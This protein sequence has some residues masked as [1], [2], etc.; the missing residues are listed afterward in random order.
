MGARGLLSRLASRDPGRPVDEV[1]SIVNNLRVLLNTRVGDSLSAMGFGVTDFIDLV[2]DAP[3]AAGAMQ[4]SIRAAIT[5]FEPRLRNVRVRNI[6]S[7]DPLA[8]A[9]EVSA[10]LAGD[11]KRGLVRV[12]T[13]VSHAGRIK[14]E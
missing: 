12:R 5:E 7:E 1:T 3:H 8:L 9:F 2:H 13:Q 14:V 4:K 10:R 6:P 11:R